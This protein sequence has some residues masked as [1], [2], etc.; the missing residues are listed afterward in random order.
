MRPA[1]GPS[2]RKR[3][4][5]AARTILRANAPAARDAARSPA[6]AGAVRPGAAPPR[7]VAVSRVPDDGSAESPPPD[8]ARPVRADPAACVT[9]PRGTPARCPGGGSRTPPERAA[10]DACPHWAERPPRAFLVAARTA[11]APRVVPR[12]RAA[13]PLAHAAG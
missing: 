3:L 4:R 13:G 11:P 1:I 5:A 8:R 12:P 6:D 7:A 9:P 2:G 10:A